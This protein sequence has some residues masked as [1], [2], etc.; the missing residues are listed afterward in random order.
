MKR[1]NDTWWDTLRH[2]IDKTQRD[3]SDRMRHMRHDKTKGDRM[4]QSK[5]QFDMMMR[6]DKIGQDM[7][8]WDTTRH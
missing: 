1:H 7:M 3:W 6:P 8:R 4:R 2:E 5:T